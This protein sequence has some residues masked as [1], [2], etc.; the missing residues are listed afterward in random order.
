MR[1]MK[2]MSARD[3]R[4]LDVDLSHVDLVRGGQRVLRDLSWH[5]RPG[6]HWVLHG[7]NGA[8]KTQLLKLI[9]GDVWP[10]PRA[11]TRRRCR[12]RGELFTEPYE[13][14]EEI[15]YLGAERQDRYPHYDWN[16]QVRTVVGTGLQR[17]DTPVRSLGATERSQVARLLRRLGILK[18]AARRFLT[19]SQ[20]EQRL[21]LLARALAWRPALLLLDEPLNGLDAPHRARFL[22]ALN[23][24]SRS[25]LPWVYAGHRL[26][27]VP[28]GVTHWA[29]LKD[30]RVRSSPWRRRA[31]RAPLR[32]PAP[33]LA[34]RARAQRSPSLLELHNASVWRAG[35]V[36][37]RGVNAR[38]RRAE[39]WVVHGPNGS[40]KSTLLATLYG[41]HA[42]A[43]Q[44][45]VRRHHHSS[46]TPLFDFQRRVGRVSP[47]LQAA[48]P[49]RQ[50]VLESIAAGMRG[51]HHLDGELTGSERRAA[52]RALGE[53]GARRLASRPFG[54]LSYGQARR[55]LFARALARAPD[56]VLLDEPYTGLDAATRQ[57][58]R[59]LVERWISRGRTIVIASHHRDDWPRGATHEIELES[60][61]ARYS[62]PLRA[63]PPVHRSSRL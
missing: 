58:L 29:R 34:S 31:P 17:T 46:G 3:G 1:E 61:R 39:C 38:V 22:A 20:G 28:R 18:L 47:E 9:A 24:L 23:T 45:S 21:T 30:G 51:A 19:L 11:E 36:V 4:Y 54:Q 55:A 62:G 26:E 56:I 52:L 6:Q 57:R 37:L 33:P 63:M 7:A 12:W 16:F 15:A 35:R 49:R 32:A 44:G 41:E 14:K 5:I 59:A 8:G 53:V 48:L 60:G 2:R 25:R 10:S 13:V 50:T 27:E 43:Q 40:G 42:V